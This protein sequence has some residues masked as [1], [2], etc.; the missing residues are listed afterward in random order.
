M[1]DR[2]CCSF[3]LHPANTSNLILNLRLSRHR[4]CSCQ[5]A[6]RWLQPFPGPSL[7]CGA[8]AGRFQLW[9]LRRP[10]ADEVHLWHPAHLHTCAGVSWSQCWSCAQRLVKAVM[11][12][13][14]EC[15]IDVL[16]QHKF[17]ATQTDILE[18]FC[19]LLLLFFSW[20]SCKNKWSENS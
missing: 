4:S 19:Y 7:R 6:T 17:N 2:R 8:P 14:T 15:Q 1:S 20:I 18:Q 13:T 9:R 10:P 3:F 16:I 11:C 5:Q 12:P